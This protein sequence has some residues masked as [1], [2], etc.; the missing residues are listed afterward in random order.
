ML[1]SSH[2]GASPR[3]K[4]LADQASQITIPPEALPFIEWGREDLLSC[5]QVSILLTIR[6]NPG[7]STGAIASALGLNKP[8]VTRA[9]DKLADMGLVRRAFQ[10]DDRRMVRLLPV[11]PKKGKR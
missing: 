3:S 2:D 8:S 4:R 9:T 11:A 5:R 7:M 10:P 1:A 6:A